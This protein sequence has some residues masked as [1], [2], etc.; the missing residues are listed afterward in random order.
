METT[1]KCKECGEELS[2]N[3]FGKLTKSKDGLRSICKSCR[4]KSEKEHYKESP[5]KSK[6]RQKRYTEGN[7]ELMN[8]RSRKHYEQN[9]E[10]MREQAREYYAENSKTINENQKR[11]NDKNAEKVK[12]NNGHYRKEN[13]EKEVIRHKKYR[14]EHVDKIRESGIAYRN[15]N[16]E[17]EYNRHKEYRQGNKSQYAIYAQTRRARKQLL[18]STLTILQWENIKKDFNNKCAY[19]GKELPL[20]QEHFLALTS[21]GEYTVNNIIPSCRSCNSS[22]NKY[23]FS[24]WYPKFRHYSKK[25][26]IFILKYLNYK[27]NNQQLALSI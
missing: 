1:K 17:Y 19:C 3:T 22:K 11:Y 20:E 9:S 15:N 16:I 12:E 25:R 4:S 8:E 7:S 21:A 23:E 18:P 10:K 27:N 2:L 13:A 6:L 24:K 26:E 5:E 14:D